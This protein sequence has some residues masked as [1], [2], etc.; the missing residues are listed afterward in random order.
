[1]RDIEEESQ[2]TKAALEKQV[3]KLQKQNLR[4]LKML[5]AA[6]CKEDISICDRTF[7]EV[8]DEFEDI[9]REHLAQCED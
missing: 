1:M 6:T 8:E 3:K 4:L 5:A 7:Q 2:E 9:L